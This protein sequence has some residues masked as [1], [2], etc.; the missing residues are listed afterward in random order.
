MNRHNAVVSPLLY[1][2]ALPVLDG[3]PQ[4]PLAALARET[5]ETVVRAGTVLRGAD[6]PVESL[7]LVLDGRLSAERDG[8]VRTVPSGDEVGLLEVVAGEVAGTRVV[9]ETDSVVL[10]IDGDAL[11]VVSER[12]SSIL[13]RLVEEVA[14]R[15]TLDRAALLA[16]V[17]GPKRA[18]PLGPGL[19]RVGRLLALHRAPA[20]PSGS[21]DALAE[22]AG[23]DA[24]VVVEAGA[25]LW[26]VGTPASAAYVLCSGTV[27]YRGADGDE[28]GAL[29]PGAV[30]GLPLMLAGGTRALS[31]W[32]RTD[33]VALELQRDAFFDVLEDHFELAWGIMAAAARRL[34]ESA[35]G[36]GPAGSADPDGPPSPASGQA[37]PAAP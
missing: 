30:P 22:L 21:M 17:A 16:A 23:V 24:E 19:D 10:G 9:A 25:P 27:A 20:L 15:L 18:E 34:L 11:R 32:A 31:A 6:E 12:H 33:V 4:G 2:R 5:E 14:R 35:A 26:E 3:L 8:V 1:L 36:P 29:G 37:P 28:F 7:H 13:V